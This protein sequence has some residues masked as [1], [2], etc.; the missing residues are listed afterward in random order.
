[1]DYKTVHV[2]VLARTVDDF[3][4]FKCENITLY[5]GNNKS[6]ENVMKERVRPPFGTIF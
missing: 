1:M 4:S 6:S 2:F 5:R 3:Y